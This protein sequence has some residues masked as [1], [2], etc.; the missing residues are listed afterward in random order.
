[1]FSLCIF[2]DSVRSLVFSPQFNG[3]DD[4]LPSCLLFAPDEG[5]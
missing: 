5:S 4:A 2:V 3:F 1:M